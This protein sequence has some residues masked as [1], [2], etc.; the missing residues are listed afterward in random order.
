VT[1]LPI[2][3]R[4]VLEGLGGLLF[5]QSELLNIIPN[6]RLVMFGGLI[7]LFLVVEPEGLNR[8]WSNIRN[9]FRMWPFSY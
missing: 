4:W 8:L 6:L 7:V 2:V 9:Y 3:T 1:L 5:S